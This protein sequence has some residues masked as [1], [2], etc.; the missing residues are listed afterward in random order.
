MSRAIFGEWIRNL[1]IEWFT[2]GPGGRPTPPGSPQ[3]ELEVGKEE[4]DTG[5]K[6]RMG[7]RWGNGG[8]V[9]RIEDEVGGIKE[10]VVNGGRDV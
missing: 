6:N 7:R 10:E 8:R 1:I 3:E 2:Q 4:T 5:W 9:E